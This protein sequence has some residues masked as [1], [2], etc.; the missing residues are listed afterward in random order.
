MKSEVFSFILQLK[1]NTGTCLLHFFF[2][3]S[4]ES[5]INFRLTKSTFFSVSYDKIDTCSLP[6]SPDISRIY[7]LLFFFF[8]LNGEQAV[9]KIIY[10]RKIVYHF[11]TLIH[12]ISVSKEAPLSIFRRYITFIFGIIFIQKKRVNLVM[13]KLLIRS[14]NVFN[15]RWFCWNLFKTAIKLKLSI[16]LGKYMEKKIIVSQTKTASW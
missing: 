8:S 13:L 7:C 5:K 9:Q 4:W 11:F 16:F 3:L 6:V 15:S 1:W 12:N 2:N 10:F 14:I